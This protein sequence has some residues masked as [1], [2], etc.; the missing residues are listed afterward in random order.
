MKTTLDKLNEELR[1]FAKTLAPD[2]VRV[3]QQSIALQVLSGV[4]LKTPVDT[5]RARANW[6]VGISTPPKGIVSEDTDPISKGT[7]TIVGNA[8]PFSVVWINNNVEYVAILETGTS[9]QAPAGMVD[10][11]LEEVRAQFFGV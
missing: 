1:V 4:V 6:Q 8:L 2:A 3:L 5:G 10:V 7:P 9:Q 11:T